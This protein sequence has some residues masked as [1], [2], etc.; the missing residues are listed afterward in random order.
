MGV[1]IKKMKQRETEGEIVWKTK[2]Q[3]ES[4]ER[5]TRS[6]KVGKTYKVPLTHLVKI[7]KIKIKKVKNREIDI[8]IGRR[9]KR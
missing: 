5:A 7:K 2:N 8:E 3:K 1:R 9:I 4:K 6:K